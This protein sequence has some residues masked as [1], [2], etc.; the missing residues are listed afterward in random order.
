VWQSRRAC[1]GHKSRIQQPSRVSK[2]THVRKISS[3]GSPS[4]HN[5]LRTLKGVMP[6]SFRKIRATRRDVPIGGAA[7]V[8]SLGL[9]VTTLV[10][11][12]TTASVVASHSLPI[13][14]AKF[15]ARE[16]GRS[17]F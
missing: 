2:R 5:P 10:A 11:K 13:A 16:E 7:L 9:P 12:P 14:F 3:N 6:S 15:G 17:T 8:T 4:T 1:M